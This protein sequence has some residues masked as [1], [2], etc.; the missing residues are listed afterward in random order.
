MKA[1]GQATLR[2]WDMEH[3]F[4][5]GHFRRWLAIIGSSN[6]SQELV[7]CPI[8]RIVY[9]FQQRLPG[10]IEF[11][12]NALGVRRPAIGFGIEIVMI[13]KA[14]DV[15]DQGHDASEAARTD[16][17]GGDFA[18]EAFHANTLPER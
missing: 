15:G 11:F 8:N 12:E 6:G 3:H 16:D 18:E 7:R 9:L 14:K 4:K 13:E 17:L 5:P 2:R 1:M 10:A